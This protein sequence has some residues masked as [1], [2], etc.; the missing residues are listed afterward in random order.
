MWLCLFLVPLALAVSLPAN[1]GAD[2]SG[3]QC[4]NLFSAPVV[5]LNTTADLLAIQTLRNAYSSTSLVVFALT[6]TLY[7]LG[8][9]QLQLTG[10]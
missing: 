4:S 7:D 6:G 5:L 9:Q 3:L 8:R 10:T 1:F 2:V